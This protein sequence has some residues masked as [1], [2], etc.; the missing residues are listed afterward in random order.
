M[1]EDIAKF[2][3]NGQK[4]SRVFGTIKISRWVLFVPHYDS[5]DILVH[6][7]RKTTEVMGAN[8]PYVTDSF[9]VVV[10]AEED[11]LEARDRLIRA[12][13]TTL[14]LPTA[15]ATPADVTAWRSANDELTTTLEEKLRRLPTLKSDRQRLQFQDKVLKWY[16]EGQSVLQALRT[17]P[18][19]YEKVVSAK[20]HRENYLVMA[21]VVGGT[22]QELLKSSIDDLRATLQSEVRELHTFSADSLTY[23]AIADWLLRCPLDFP[24]EITNG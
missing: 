1:T 23:E 14:E 9:R 21:A 19:V 12:G 11:F 10:C 13:A 22:P 6:A 5:K 20:S 17:Y 2:I 3:N 7:S 4:L 8:L 18:E 16:L 24:D 15:Q